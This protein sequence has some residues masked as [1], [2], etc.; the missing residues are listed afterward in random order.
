LIWLALFLGLAMGATGGLL[1]AA[2]LG[3][4]SREDDMHDLCLKCE[5]QRLDQA[6]RNCEQGV[7]DD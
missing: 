1:V 4:G 2:M 3:A 6:F 7:R 5:R